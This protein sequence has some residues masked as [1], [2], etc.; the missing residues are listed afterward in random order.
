MKTFIRIL[1]I[2][3][4]LLTA[5]YCD[6]LNREDGEE[7]N[8]NGNQEAGQVAILINHNHTDLNKIPDKWIDE[9]KSKFRIHYAHTSHGGQIVE[10]LTRLSAGTRPQS[11]IPMNSRFTFLHSYCQIPAGNGMRMMD[12]QQMGYCETYITPELYWQGDD[13]L[14][15]T[16]NVLNSFDVNVSIWA[17]CSQLDY[18]SKSEVQA[19]LDNMAKLEKEFPDVTFIYMTGNAQSEEQNRVD[20]NNQIRDYCSDN[21]KILFD[22][23]DL[24]CWYNGQQHSSGGIPTEHPRV[25]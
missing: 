3:F 24:D 6:S 1:L 12:G 5:I 23:A 22:F 16:R 9:V 21:N 20:R 2:C 4:F 17:W 13:A 19:Y 8:D 25:R 11:T 15:Y 7:N 14:S 10:G 18:Y